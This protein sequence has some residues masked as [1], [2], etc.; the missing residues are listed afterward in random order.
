MYS[1]DKHSR[2]DH[3]VFQKDTAA[4]STCGTTTRGTSSAIMLE[5][6]QDLL[7]DKH[8]RH[9]FIRVMADILAKDDIAAIIH[10]KAKQ[11]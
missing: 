6:R 9:A 11:L 1:A 8:W 7:T 10:K 5:M 2:G 3:H 4:A